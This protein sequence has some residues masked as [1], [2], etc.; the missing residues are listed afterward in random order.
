MP[1]PVPTVAGG[2][3]VIEPPSCPQGSSIKGALWMLG[4]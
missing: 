3:K 4:D 2:T 1:G